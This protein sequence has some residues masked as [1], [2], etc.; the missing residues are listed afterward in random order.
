MDTDL[1]VGQIQQQVIESGFAQEAAE[2]LA[3]M[4]TQTDGFQSLSGL[5]EFSMR[6][7]NGNV[8]TSEELMLMGI[9]ANIE[10][11]DDVKVQVRVGK[12]SKYFTDG[13]AL[14]LGISAEFTIDVGDGGE[15]K[16][17]LSATFVEELAVDIT[18]SAY[19]K[20]K[21]IFIV[22][23]FKKLVFSTAVD[24]K[25]YAGVSVDV[26]IYT[27]E[28]EEESIWE[29]LKGINNG[30]FKEVFEQIEDLKN[31][32]DQAK[33]TVE[34]IAG[35]K[36]DLK[37]L[38]QAVPSDLTNEEEY[39][40][41]L[42]TLGELN[43][44]QE[45][46]GMLNLT[47][48][49]ELD[50]GVRNLM[51]RYSEMLE[52][53]SDW[54]EIVNKKIFE[55]EIHIKIFAIG[56]SAS[57]VIKGNVNIALGAN[58]EYV[59]GKRYS[60]WFDIVSKTSGSSEMD[61][62]DEK[63]AFQFYV[64]GELGLRM[65]VEAEICVGIISTK[66]GSIGVTAE[67]G[68]Y[69]KMW[70]YFIYEYTKLRPANTSTW[71]Y[72]E[73]ML[74][75]LYLEFG[76]YLEITFKATLVGKTMYQPTLLD[77][78]WPLLTAGTRLNVYDFAYEVEEDESLLVK[79][80]D[81]NSQN[82]IA[83]VLPESYRL[84]EY[85]DLVEGDTAQSIYDYG[86]F[87]YTLS[88]RHFTFDEQTGLITVTVPK[89][90]QYMTCDLTLT[91]KA[92]KLTFSSYDMSITIPLVWTN[93]SED[94]LNQRF[95]AA[96]RVGNPNDGYTTVWSQRVVK[97]APFD[98]PTEEKIRELL[99]VSQYEAGMQGNL[100]YASIS[101][102]QD[103]VLTGLTILKDTVYYF[104]VTPRTYTLT[105]LDVENSDGTKVNRQ[106]T[107]KFGDAFNFS[108]LYES[109][110]DDDIT[111]TYTSFLK[112]VAKDGLNKEIIRDFNQPVSLGFAAELLSGA[113]YTAT[114]ADHSATVIFT[115]E[116]VDINPIEVKM[117]KGDVPTMGAFINL[118]TAKNAMVKSI[119]PIFAP[120]TGA[121]SYTVVCEVLQV[122]IV[123]RTITYQTNGGSEIVQLKAPEGS[124]ITQPEAPVRAGYEFDGWYSDDMLTL[125]FTF[126]VMPN[127]DTTLYAKWK[128]V[129][130]TVTFDGNEG[131]LGQDVPNTK[132]VVYGDLYGVLPVPVRTGFAFGG[133][134]T[135]RTQGD[136]VT[137]E[138]VVN[139]TQQHTLYAHWTDKAMINPD[140]ISFA[141]D[142]IHAYDMM[143][144]PVVFT[145]GDS[146]IEAGSFTVAYKRQNIDNSWTSEAVNA[147]VYDVKVTRGEDEAYQS[148]EKTFTGVMTIH[149]I[150]RTIS[151]IPT[152]SSYKANILVDLLPE[153]AYL[154]DGVVEYA[155]STTQTAPVTG[156]QT[157][158]A[159]MNLGTGSYYLFVRVNEG[160]NYLVT[161]ASVSN[162]TFF[163][164][165]IAKNALGYYLMM[166]IATSNIDNAGT[167][168][169]IKGLYDYLDGSAS[170]VTHFDKDGNDFEQGDVDNYKVDAPLHDPWML[171]Q[172]TILYEKK[173]TKP[174]WH[175]KSITPYATQAVEFG[176]IVLEGKQ[177]HTGDVLSV[178]QWFGAEDHDMTFVTWNGD[179]TGMERQITSVGNFVEIPESLVLTSGD[180]ETYTFTYDGMV[181]DQYAI[182]DKNDVSTPY[183][184][185]DHGDAPM[186]AINADD[187]IYNKALSYTINSMTIDKAAL[188]TA[189]KANNDTEMMITVTLQFPTR[190]T[191]PETATYTKTILVTLGD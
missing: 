19:A 89:D 88:N 52:N 132:T 97:N 103:Q 53:E 168:S 189:M 42:D 174:G 57:F 126:T 127:A 61:L 41:M 12:S 136:L 93:L 182:Q 51:E 123:E 8:L 71:D 37:K 163:V 9:G 149:K 31:K 18:A 76:L 144:H 56:I 183:N 38:W 142:Q 140:I 129:E 60:F 117:K 47:N 15:L 173:G 155:A 150:N 63:F 20:I 73:R 50:A 170:T 100:K 134:Y 137:A 39:E 24:I 54:I 66:I 10:L 184:A 32:I 14:E 153:G 69:V 109:G 178:N 138:T 26:K 16:I 78:E 77:K 154:G 74:G 121:T 160:E 3:L 45:L 111:K 165:G 91:W 181:I 145:T 79:D 2:Y 44:T 75:A 114:Y 82:G 179:V 84:M 167:D 191:T 113:T 43:V 80:Q 92:D 172:V 152:G 21:W 110:S 176:S 104:D 81:S 49:D 86:K 141:P 23:K 59:I 94:E 175:C 33:D 35:Y 190:S 119:D 4:V 147:G 64:M 156:W 171:S 125:A 58:M 122:P 143:S 25:N 151:A 116:G 34:Q 188:Y 67:F 159:I 185:Y 157:S 68:P 72:D 83:M 120:I 7:Q 27:V 135:D 128:G 17:D 112:I 96:V 164:E 95:T 99:S 161:P 169:I 29:K 85:M 5:K 36:D 11:S 65:G 177:K 131:E 22:P 146:G 48:E 118:V 106:Y 124:I 162:D 158:R 187:A 90:T 101:G 40:G 70:G 130:T 28:K 166:T 13:I 186:L 180:L 115:F 46:M 102:Y 98:L 55:K 139:K 108:D 105:I 62:L 30:S 1:L 6:D 133:W 148:F 107:A 87:H